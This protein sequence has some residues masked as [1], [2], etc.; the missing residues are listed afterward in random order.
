MGTNLKYSISIFIFVFFQSCGTNTLQQ[1]EY[2]SNGN[3]KSVTQSY[4][5]D[6]LLKVTHWYQNGIKKSEEYR[7]EGLF[8]KEKKVWFKSGSIKE[9]RLNI[10]LDTIISYENENT[11]ETTSI[12]TS[13][14]HRKF[15]NNGQ[16]KKSGRVV[17]SNKTGIWVFR[18]SIGNKV[19]E[20]FF[21][22]D[23]LISE[24]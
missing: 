5:K 9:K 7:C 18:D 3:V 13:F 11:I 1:K 23:S 17:F 2:W 19:S 12:V 6:S 8:V 21:R 24:S 4:E 22:N 10:V 16:I 20:Q 14:D 15:Y